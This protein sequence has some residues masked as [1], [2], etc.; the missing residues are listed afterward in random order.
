MQS[1]NGGLLSAT[2]YGILEL[3]PSK[4]LRCYA[5]AR[6]STEWDTVLAGPN[7]TSESRQDSR[8]RQREFSQLS[9]RQIMNTGP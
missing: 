3:G 8:N 9:V 6:G 1:E 5:G 7:Q 2:T 4:S